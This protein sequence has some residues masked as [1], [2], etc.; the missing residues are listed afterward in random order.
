MSDIHGCYDKFM[1]MLEFKGEDEVYIIGDIFD[2]GAEPLK[3]LDY[4]VGHKNVTL[5]KGNHEN[6]F[7]EAFESKDYRGMIFKWWRSNTQS[8]NRRWNRQGKTSL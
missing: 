4:V 7:E 5:L 1:S 8:N 6:M 3:I 2:R